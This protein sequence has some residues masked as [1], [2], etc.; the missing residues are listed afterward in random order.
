M[1][2]GRRLS[3]GAVDDIPIVVRVRNARYTAAVP[4]PPLP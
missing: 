2:W 3:V 4:C 1:A